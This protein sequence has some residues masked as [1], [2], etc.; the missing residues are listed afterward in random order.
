M[1]LILIHFFM[2]ENGPFTFFR[3]SLCF[4]T[5]D[6]TFDISSRNQKVEEISGTQN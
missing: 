3:F 4:E 5:N 2:C 1:R 6:K